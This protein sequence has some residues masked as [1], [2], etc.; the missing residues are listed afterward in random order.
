MISTVRFGASPHSTEAAVKATVQIK[1]K[2]LRPRTPAS[3]PVAGRITALAA[4]YEVSTQEISSTPADSDPCMWGR[5]TLMTVTSSTC[6]TVT[7]MTV[8]VMAHRRNVL[9]GTST[10]D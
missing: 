2:R 5:A 8:A 3:H 10:S 9:I 1:K 6:I 4:R 7:V